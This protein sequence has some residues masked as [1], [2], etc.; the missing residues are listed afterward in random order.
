MPIVM[1]VFVTFLQIQM[2]WGQA[3][4][5]PTIAPAVSYMQPEWRMWN[6]SF[7]SSNYE[8][9]NSKNF[10]FA[11]VNLQNSM[12]RNAL[13]KVDAEGALAFNAPLMSYIKLTEFYF[14]LPFSP[15]NAKTTPSLMLGR[16]KSNWSEL[17]ARWNLGVW[18]PVF[19]WNPINPERQGLTGLFLYFPGQYLDI[20][21]MG[22]PLYLPDQGPSFQVN[23]DGEFEKGNPWFKRPADSVRVVPGGETSRVEYNFKRPTDTDVVMQNT[24][25]ARGR[26]KYEQISL[27]GSYAYK[28]MNQLPLAYTGALDVSRDKAVVDIITSVQYHELVGGDLR[29]QGDV[30]TMGVSGLYDRPSGSADFENES[31]LTRPVYSEARIFSPY[32][33][34]KL[35]KSLL[36]K[37]QHLN[38]TG[39]EVKETGPL[40]NSDRASIS[41]RY[42]FHEAQSA[43]LAYRGKLGARR[44]WQS[45]IAYTLSE[46]NKFDILRWRGQFQMGRIWSLFSEALLVRAEPELAERPSEMAEFDNHDRVLVGVGYVF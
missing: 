20:E 45:S 41:P 42:P 22:S 27:Q 35:S 40:A 6:D 37:L 25:S 10:N 39:G 1:L 7:I 13:L 21:L 26:F 46:K 34:L 11:G 24:Y 38:I 17:D 43:E 29:Y 14:D 31:A 32:M 28:P 4:A 30:V 16:K 9:T 5:T 15:A 3:P 44:G 18:E 12:D 19:K 2:S 33:D 36:L 23:E 8:A